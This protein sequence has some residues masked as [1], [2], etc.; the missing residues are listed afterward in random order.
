MAEQLIYQGMWEK[1]KE[2]KDLPI[3]EEAASGL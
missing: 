1:G 2:R 3:N